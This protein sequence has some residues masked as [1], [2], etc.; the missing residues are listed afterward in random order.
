MLLTYVGERLARLAKMLPRARTNPQ[1]QPIP[2]YIR[3]GESGHRQ[4]ARLH[5]EGHFSPR[6]VV[7]D[8]SRF[9]WQCDLVAALQADG[10]QIVLDTKAAE[11]AAPGLFDGRAQGAPWGFAGHGRPLGPEHFAPD[12]RRDLVG[13]MARFAVATGVDA[14]LA[15]GHFLEHGP[16]SEWFAVDRVACLALRD[17]LDREGGKRIRIDYALLLPRAAL[18]EA[19]ARAHLVDG[20]KDLPFENL[21]I[22]AAGFGALA[23]PAATRQYLASVTGLSALGKPIVADCLGGLVGL[24]AH[25]FGAVAGLAEGVG[26]R[27]RFDVRHW[28][29]P[30][31][32]GERPGVRRA[33]RVIVPGL[34]RA[35]TSRDLSQLAAARGGRRLISCADPACCPRGLD[36]MLADPRRHNF[37]CRAAQVRALEQIPAHDRAR[38]F[39]DGEMTRAVRLARQMTTLRVDDAALAKRLADH[40]ARTEKLQAV[41]EDLSRQT[42]EGSRLTSIFSPR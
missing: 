42:V 6:R 33:R 2:H 13:S 12:A 41:L 22:R 16:A 1:A 36:D 10:A 9:A 5:A 15:P 40:A 32:P 31:P 21:W 37:S 35:L 38:H 30:R 3:L 29:R 18:D 24:A 28:T 23:G 8:A 27:E 26:E 25:A 11:L 17:A 20:L 34:G 7:V 19:A 4:L 14:V 39:L